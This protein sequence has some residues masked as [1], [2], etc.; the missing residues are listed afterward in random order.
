VSERSSLSPPPTT[1]RSRSQACSR[2]STQP[3]AGDALPQALWDARDF[4]P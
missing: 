4:R 1:G 2:S 3:K